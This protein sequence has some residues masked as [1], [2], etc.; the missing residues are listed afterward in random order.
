MFEEPVCRR[1]SLPSMAMLSRIA[2]AV[3][4]QV[5]IRRRELAAG[6]GRI[7]HPVRLR[8]RPGWRARCITATTTISSRCSSMR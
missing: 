7:D 1:R 4:K 3:G 5:E 6:E 8:Q 2:A